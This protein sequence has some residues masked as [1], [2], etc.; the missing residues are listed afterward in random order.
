MAATSMRDWLAAN[1]RLPSWVLSG[2]F[3]TALVALLL[4]LMP[5]Y[6]PRPPVG[7]SEEPLR[8]IGIVVKERGELIEPNEVQHSDHP[9]TAQDESSPLPRDPLEPQNA[10]PDAPAISSPLPTVENVPGIGP[11]AALPEGLPNPKELIKSSGTGGAGGSSGGIPGT[12]FMGIKDNATRVVYVIDASGSMYRHNAIAKAKGAL[13]ASLNALDAGQQFQIIFYSETPQ[14]MSLR[15]V[16][17]KQLYFAT[18]LNKNNAQRFVQQIQP[19]AGTEHLSAIKLGL[20]FNPEVMYVLTDSGDPKLTP[21]ELDEIQKRN[22]GRTRIHC[23][24]FGVGKELN[25]DSSNFLKKLA[26]QNDGTH[27]YVDVLELSR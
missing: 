24:E 20:S 14:V 11:G 6:N 1:R 3:H 7:D 25:G 5:Y 10:V 16:P 27:R 9:T 12:S 8:E 23:I 19:D 26:R 13:V 21:R 22:G 17:K 18:D 4:W 15:S 2:L